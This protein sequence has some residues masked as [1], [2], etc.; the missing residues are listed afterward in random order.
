MVV[1]FW[2][3]RWP[4]PVSNGINQTHCFQV[5][6]PIR[7]FV[8]KPH[9]VGDRMPRRES[10]LVGGTTPGQPTLHGRRRE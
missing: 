4:G 6:W 7:L 2:M 8:A 9:R 3:R 1:N 5:L 10:H